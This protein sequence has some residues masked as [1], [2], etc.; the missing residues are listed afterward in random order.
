MA[1]LAGLTSV[2]SS[3]A[4]EFGDDAIRAAVEEELD[5]LLLIF[6]GLD[7]ETFKAV[8]GQ[9][10]SFTRGMAQIEKLLAAK[11]LAGKQGPAVTAVM[12]RHPAN[13]HQW[14]AFEALFSA[15]PGVSHQLATFSA[16]N[17]AVASIV[18]LKKQLADDPVQSAADRHAAELNTQVCNYPWSSVCVLSD[19]RVVPCCRDVNGS[20]VLGDLKHQSLS[21]IWNGP[22]MVR[23]RRALA[24]GDRD[25]PLCRRCTE[26]SLEIG[27]PRL[28]LKELEDLVRDLERPPGAHTQ[29]EPA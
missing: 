22:A 23:L 10:A 15:M 5:E 19:G 12:I 7:D 1:R 11:R 20:Y 14:D 2:S 4:C 27:L 21:E 3:T 9:R 29:E 28:N 24:A 6:D 16:F 17:G 8:R 25:N 26:A 13:R 18:E